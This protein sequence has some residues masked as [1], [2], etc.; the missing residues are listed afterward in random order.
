MPG[1]VISLLCLF[2]ADP[3]V[4]LTL[5]RA[6]ICRYDYLA[7]KSVIA[8]PSEIG[9]YIEKKLPGPAIQF[10]LWNGESWIPIRGMEFRRPQG[11]KGKPPLLNINATYAEYNTIFW[12][13]KDRYVFDQPGRFKLRAVVQL[14]GERVESEAVAFTVKPRA[15]SMIKRIKDAGISVATLGGRWLTPP[16]PDKLVALEDVGGNIGA[17]VTNL[18]LMDR[19]VT[20]EEN[21]GNDVL[22]YVCAQM[23]PLDAEMCLA[24]LGNHYFRKQDWENLAKVNDSF[25]ENSWMKWQWQASLDFH[26]RKVP[27]LIVLPEEQKKP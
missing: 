24:I 9:V 10:E 21:T 15:P 16:V 4:A 11:A 1:C 14:S 18:R 8:N 17:G 26:L 25:A 22:R 3:T 27:T 23:D 6:E 7:V 20:G 2:A 19:I 5:N 13:E 12:D